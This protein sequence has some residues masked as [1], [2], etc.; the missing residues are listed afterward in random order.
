MIRAACFAVLT[1]WG[2]TAATALADK[3][4][5]TESRHP[6]AKERRA[7]RAK[8]EAEME[9]DGFRP[10]PRIVGGRSAADGE[11]PWMVALLDADDPNEYDGFYCGASLIHPYWVLTAAH[12]VL[13]SRAE[14]INVLVGTNDLSN[15]GGGSQRIAVSEIVI[16]PTYNDFTMDGDFALLRLAQPANGTTIPVIDDPGHALSGVEA[17]VTG[18]GDT[19]DGHGSYPSRLEEVELPIVDLDLANASP[20][21]A[22]TLTGNMLAAG[23]EEGGKDSCQGDSGGPLIVPSPRAPGWAQAGLVSFGEGCA[24]PGAYGIYTRIGNYRDFITG[25][26]RPNYAAW[27]RANG[28]SGENVDLD[29]NGRTNF[30]EWALPDGGVIGKQISGGFL[31]LRYLRPD[32]A[33]EAKYVL[34]HA[35]SAGGPWAAV[36]GVELQ[37]EPVSE[38]LS[39]AVVRFPQSVDTG[40][41]RVRVEFSAELAYG[42]R[43]LAYPGTASGQLGLQDGLI[44]NRRF[45]TYALGFPSGTGPVAIS[46]RSTDFKAALRLEALGTGGS[47]VDVDSDAGIGLEGTDEWYEFTP[48]TGRSYRVWVTTTDSS[49]E[50]AFQLNVFDPV[51]LEAVPVLTVP[52]AKALAGMLSAND[53]PDPFFLPGA[54][55]YKDDYLLDPS[56]LTPGKL[57]EFRMTSKGNAAKGIDDFL[58]LIDGES[59][60]LVA[61]NDNFAGKANDAGLRFIPVPG[62]TYVLRA[63]ASEERDTGSYQLAATSPTAEAKKSNVGAIVVGG[64][65]SGKLSA[66]S[67]L[68]ERYFTFKYDYLLSQVAADQEVAVTLESTKFDA[69]LVVLDASD[70]TVVT[71]GDGGGPSGGRDNAKAVFTARAGRHYLIRATTYDTLEKGAYVLKTSAAP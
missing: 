39:D 5:I 52:R 10:I 69:Y 41:Y 21:Y 29:E 49:E 24:E 22:G 8:I 60:R 65:A 26:I 6:T 68:D 3:H 15:P 7:G 54:T 45:K 18:W 30:E 71:E 44:G 36:A 67:E 40:V 33:P 4:Q 53:L 55:Y 47:I 27:E 9:K 1:L 23:L 70:L 34:E 19:T 16:S 13:G 38:G 43:P 64:S 50:G 14:D 59:G 51:A 48:E 12:C 11:Y 58:G 57:L 25:H 32:V 2:M 61:G 31:Y 20:A 62:K 46:L 42:D 66:A 63:S 17:T 37:L 35:T 28:R 56:T